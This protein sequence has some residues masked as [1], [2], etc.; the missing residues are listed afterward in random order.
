MNNLYRYSPIE[1]KDN[2]LEAVQYVA[3]NTTELCKKVT[4]TSYPISSLTVFS[5]YPDEFELLKKILLGL[6]EKVSENNGPFVKLKKP[7][8]FNNSEISLV[9]I[10]KPDPYRLHVGCNDF[11]VLNYDEFKRTFLSKH[12]DN[13]RLIE[14]PKYEM[15]EF[16]DPDYDVLAYVLS[17]QF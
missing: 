5:H 13:L 2:F 8:Q 1:T 9:R 14:R 11:K 15:I 7:I 16:F 17:G 10:R 4:E 3:K 12:P 6:G